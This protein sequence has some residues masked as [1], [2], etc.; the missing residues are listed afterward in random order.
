MQLAAFGTPGTQD[1]HRDMLS[2]PRSF[3]LLFNNVTVV[4]VLV[5]LQRIPG[6][7]SHVFCAG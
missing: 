3:V 5:F 2:V 4:Q 1:C 7:C 6:L